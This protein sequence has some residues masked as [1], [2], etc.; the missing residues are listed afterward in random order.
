MIQSGMISAANEEII[1]NFNFQ[2]F[3]LEPWC[4]HKGQLILYPNV[5][6]C[7][8]DKVYTC[9]GQRFAAA[10]IPRLFGKNPRSHHNGITGKVPTGNQRLSHEV[11]QLLWILNYQCP[12]SKHKF[13][14]RNCKFQASG[15]PPTKELLILTLTR[16]KSYPQSLSKDWDLNLKHSSVENISFLSSLLCSREAAI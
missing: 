11:A 2:S 5:D 16:I 10:L 1:L 12:L 15:P 9:L 7:Q 4:K 3:L 6:L 13:L 14:L 8:Y